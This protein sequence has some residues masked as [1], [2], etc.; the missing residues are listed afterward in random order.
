[1]QFLLYLP[2][3]ITLI[4]PI[5]ERHAVYI[6]VVEIEVNEIRVKVFSDDLR[7]AIR[8]HAGVIAEDNTTD[9]CNKYQQEIERYFSEKLSLVINDESIPFK[10]ESATDEG[11]SYWIKF[12]FDQEENWRSIEVEDKHFM[13]LFPTQSN[14]IK[15]NGP[16]LRFGRLSVNQTSCS[17]EF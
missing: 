13:E 10:Y 4:S 16:A 2:L 8:N 17:F 5:E 3:L 11:D 14:I 1:M 9:F 6:S 7:D 12:Q 15:V